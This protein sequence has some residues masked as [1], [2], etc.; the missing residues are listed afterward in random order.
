M[1]QGSVIKTTLRG[2]GVQLIAAY[3]IGSMVGGIDR[4]F[5]DHKLYTGNDRTGCDRLAD[6]PWFPNGVDIKRNM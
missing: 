4:G 2:V 3:P 1:M 6:Q 5:D